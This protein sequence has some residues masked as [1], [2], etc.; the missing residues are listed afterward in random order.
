MK[1]DTGNAISIKMYNDHYGS[2]VI[3]HF[4]KNR[5]WFV[6]ARARQDSRRAAR[7]TG[8]EVPLSVAMVHLASTHPET[9]PSELWAPIELEDA[10]STAT[11]E[12]GG[13][14]TLRCMSCFLGGRESHRSEIER[15]VRRV[16]SRAKQPLLAKRIALRAECKNNSHFRAILARLVLAGFVEKLPEKVGYQAVRPDLS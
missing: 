9:I 11:P 5:R 10:D 1:I 3:L 12:W 15:R 2:D 4:T 13:A 7:P 6:E 8:R 14:V 16:L